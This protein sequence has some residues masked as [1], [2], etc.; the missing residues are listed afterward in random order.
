MPNLWGLYDMHGT[1]WEWVQDRWY[2]N[3]E[4]APSDGS[5][6]EDGDSPARVIRGGGWIISAGYCRSA[7]RW[8]GT[9]D[10]SAFV[11]LRLLRKL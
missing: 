7:Y 1:V 11:G 10:R 2:N 4:G 9:D 6:W 5:A 3:Y 8:V